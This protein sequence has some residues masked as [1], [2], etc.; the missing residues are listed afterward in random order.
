MQVVV[1]TEH[2]GD[3]SGCGD[4]SGYGDGRGDGAGGYLEAAQ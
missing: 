4:G 3:G 2:R 1:T